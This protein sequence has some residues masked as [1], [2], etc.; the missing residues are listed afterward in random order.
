[1]T[2][3]VMA[4]GIE[5]Y[6]AA[7]VGF[8]DLMFNQCKPAVFLTL[9]LLLSLSLVSCHKTATVPHSVQVNWNPPAHPPTYYEV[10]R[11]TKKG[12][13][14]ATKPYAPRVEGTQFLDKNVTAGETYYYCVKSVDE[15]GKSSQKSGCSEIV[16][17]VPKP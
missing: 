13:Y 17:V 8:Y 9:L 7:V 2:G 4:E 1:M 14:D 15:T 16:V 3:G 12:V 11:S 6:K 10:F 5:K